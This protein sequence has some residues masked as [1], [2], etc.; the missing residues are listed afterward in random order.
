MWPSVDA[1]PVP[2]P[3]TESNEKAS[4]D[5]PAGVRVLQ[6]IRDMREDGIIAATALDAPQYPPANED[7]LL[8]I[9]QLH[10]EGDLFYSRTYPDADR[11]DIIFIHILASNGYS[12]EISSAAPS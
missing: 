1:P 10:D 3:V 6:I 11:S 8:Q 12:A 9:F 2:R 7:D 5:D 4:W